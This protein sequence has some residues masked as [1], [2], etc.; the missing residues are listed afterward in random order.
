MRRVAIAFAA[1]FVLGATGAAAIV[2]W[3]V[4]AVTGSPKAVDIGGAAAISFA[5]VLVGFVVVLRRVGLPFTDVVSAAG[6]VA[7]GDY[8]VRIEEHGPPSLRSVARAFNSMTAQLQSQDE[9]RRNLMA[10]VAHELR[11]PLTVMQGQLEGILDGVYPR[12]DE[13][14]NEVLAQARLLSRLVEDLR[15]LAQAERGTLALKKEP[16]DLAELADDTVGSLAVEA[17]AAGVAIRVERPEAALVDADPIRIR[18]VLTN[19]LSNAVRHSSRGGTVTIT[20]ETTREATTVNVRDTGTGIAAEALP[21]IF[22]RFYKDRSSPGSGLGLTIARNFVVAH[23]GTM[24]AASRLGEGT[25]ITFTLP[26][27]AA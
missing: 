12:D 26:R 10:D 7:D 9:Q 16:I 27:R 13:R 17:A 14:L 23:G 3:L 2:S 15:T 19:L 6:R 11:T 5:I 21:H 4:S 25:T 22:D 8:G 20:I 24:T 18:E 1:F